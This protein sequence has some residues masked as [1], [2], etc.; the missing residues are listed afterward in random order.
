MTQA[1]VGRELKQGAHRDPGRA[2]S[3][4]MRWRRNQKGRRGPFDSRVAVLHVQIT[5]TFN[6]AYEYPDSSHASFASRTVD[7]H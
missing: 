6:E 7:V 3:G 2:V 4:G 1:G 5:F